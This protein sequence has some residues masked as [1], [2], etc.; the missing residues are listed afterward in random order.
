VPQIVGALLR[1]GAAAPKVGDLAPHV[2]ER[3]V[4]IADGAGALRGAG[5]GVE[6]A[7]LRIG[8][9]QRLGLVLAVQVHEQA[10][11]LRR[12]SRR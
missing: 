8:I 5:E 4:R 1:V 2:R 12:G 9:E 7:A 10:G 3:V 6:D 11:R